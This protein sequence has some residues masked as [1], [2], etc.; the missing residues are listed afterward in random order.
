MRMKPALRRS[1]V[2]WEPLDFMREEMDERKDK[3]ERKK[4]VK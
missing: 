2:S 1:G 3:N 4:I